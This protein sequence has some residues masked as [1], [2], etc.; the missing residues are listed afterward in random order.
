MT[1]FMPSHWLSTHP[2]RNLYNSLLRK[3]PLY[4]GDVR[5]YQSTL[6]GEVYNR[7]SPIS[8]VWLERNIRCRSD[9][10]DPVSSSQR[11]DFEHVR[12]M[13]RSG[14]IKR[15]PRHRAYPRKRSIL[16][17]LSMGGPTMGEYLL[18]IQ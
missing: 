2:I 8:T 9:V 11:R 13:D 14:S 6:L 17:C 12:S 7:E 15:L 10:S 16:P 4:T 3:Q 18:L 1:D 5:R